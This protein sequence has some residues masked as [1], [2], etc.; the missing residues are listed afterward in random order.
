MPT[1]DELYS[2]FEATTVGIEC[3][4]REMPNEINNIALQNQQLIKQHDAAFLEGDQSKVSEIMAQ[5]D[6]NDKKIQWLQHQQKLLLSKDA[7]R[8][9]PKLAKLARQWQEQAGKEV[10]ALHAEWKEAE[11][12]TEQ[13]ALAYLSC[14]AKLGNIGRRATR[15]NNQANRFV[16][17]GHTVMLGGLPNDRT[18]PNRQKGAPWQVNDAVITK[19]YKAGRMEE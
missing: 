10:P 4:G 13:A 16:E 1:C 15:L 12:A 11:A 2:E 19:T 8:S 5:C 9:N 7:T 17:F 14:V 3:R 18:D 6:A